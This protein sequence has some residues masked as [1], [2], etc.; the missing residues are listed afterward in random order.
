MQQLEPLVKPALRIL[1]SNAKLRAMLNRCNEVCQYFLHSCAVKG[2]NLSVVLQFVSPHN[3][4][5]ELH[6]QSA[7]WVTCSP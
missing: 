3:A 4:C 5:N 7:Q 1:Q 2:C 6:D